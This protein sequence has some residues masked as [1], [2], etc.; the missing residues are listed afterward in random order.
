MTARLAWGP[1]TPDED[2][3]QW[4]EAS[5]T[6]AHGGTWRAEAFPDGT[7]W[8]WR[9]WPWWP[10]LRP[11]AWGFSQSRAQALRAAESYLAREGVIPFPPD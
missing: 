3:A 7:L 9:V 6:D 10:A 5:V 1:P 11:E 8:T 4:R 2:L